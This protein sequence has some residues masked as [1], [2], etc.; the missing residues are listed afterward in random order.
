MT[1]EEEKQKS[2][3]NFIYLQIN[4]TNGNNEVKKSKKNTIFP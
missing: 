3:T 1:S 4:T 2:A